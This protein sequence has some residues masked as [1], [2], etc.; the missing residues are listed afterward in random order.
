MQFIPSR[1]RGIGRGV[2][3]RRFVP[4]CTHPSII[5]ASETKDKRL[6]REA[7]AP[8][9][10]QAWQN[11]SRGFF[12]LSNNVNQYYVR[13]RWRRTA[14]RGSRC[15][16]R[17]QARCR[18]LR[19]CRA[20]AWTSSR[21][22]SRTSMLSC[23]KTCRD[24]PPRRTTPTCARPLAPCRFPH[25]TGPQLRDGFPGRACRVVAAVLTA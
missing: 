25:S 17:A 21:R 9:T 16:R 5:T 12:E 22:A 23:Q 6:N 1:E 4:Q 13:R 15:R 14:A 19:T 8:G 3:A 10:P 20:S 7:L 18:C 24:W 2:R 11:P